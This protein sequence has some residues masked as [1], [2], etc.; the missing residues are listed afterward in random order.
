VT[1]PKL[2]LNLNVVEAKT[3]GGALRYWLGAARHKMAH[4]EEPTKDT[5]EGKLADLLREYNMA[6]NQAAGK[7]EIARD[8]LIRMD[9]G[10]D[11]A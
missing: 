8:I 4:M 5:A 1:E 9:A 2:T 11:P 7:M 10:G 6:R 3:I